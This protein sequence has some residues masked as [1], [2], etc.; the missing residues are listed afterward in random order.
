M[1]AQTRPVRVRPR[2]LLAAVV[3]LAAVVPAVLTVPAAP[4]EAAT[5]RQRVERHLHDLGYPVGRV[6]GRFTRYTRL[7][8][9]A[10]RDTHGM[11]ATRHG[12]TPRLRRSILRATA[13]PRTGRRDGLYVSRKCQVVLRVKDGRYRLLARASTGGPGHRTPGGVGHVWRKWAGW[14]ES[15]IYSGARMYDSVYFRR[16]RPGIALHGSVSDSYV[17]PY[18]A[19]HGC[20]RVQRWA[21]RKIFRST[22]RGTRVR[23]Y[24]TY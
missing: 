15:S 11:R 18:P 12:L 6:D 5:V 10:W 24:G 13:R 17:K 1:V 7:G 4:A 20:V 19:S 3:V 9:C 21:I 16:D 8:L 14:H 23:V 22:P 2:R